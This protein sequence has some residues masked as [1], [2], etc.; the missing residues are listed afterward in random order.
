MAYPAIEMEVGDMNDAEDVIGLRKT[1]TG[2]CD[3]LY[4]MEVS[5]EE[6]APDEED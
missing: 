6:I 3:G 1:L 5:A 4:L 2:D